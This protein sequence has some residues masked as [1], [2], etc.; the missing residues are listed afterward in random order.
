MYP[1]AEVAFQLQPDTSTVNSTLRLK[2]AAQTTVTFK[3]QTT[4]PEAYLV[5]PNIGMLDPG[6]TIEVILTLK[7]LKLH[8][9]QRHKFLILAAKIDSYSTES[10]STTWSKTPKDAI[11]T[12]ILRVVFEQSGISQPRSSIP[13]VNPGVCEDH[14]LSPM[15][16]KELLNANLQYTELVK[17]YVT[18]T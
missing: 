18:D 7:T 5:R 11:Q 14:S 1:A 12:A 17:F 8:P 16:A 4:V 10:I 15:T 2:N 13:P 6:D 3:I 9:T